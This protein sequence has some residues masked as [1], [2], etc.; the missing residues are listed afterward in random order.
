MIQLKN[1][2]NVMNY[3]SHPNNSNINDRSN[4]SWQLRISCACQGKKQAVVY[5][6]KP[7]RDHGLTNIVGGR[8]QEDIVLHLPGKVKRSSW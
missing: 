8:I 6:W 4:R 2:V 3:N 7:V 5:W 1:G